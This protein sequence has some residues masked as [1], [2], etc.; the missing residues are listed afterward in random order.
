MI[1]PMTGGVNTYGQ[2]VYSL[3]QGDMID[4]VI[5]V[6]SNNTVD[7][8]YGAD[9]VVLKYLGIIGTEYSNTSGN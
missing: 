8:R 2:T 5:D 9:N 3:K 4:I 1:L 6:P 7:V